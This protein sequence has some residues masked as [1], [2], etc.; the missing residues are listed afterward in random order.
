MDSKGKF[1]LK[2]FHNDNM[3]KR[4]LTADDVKEMGK[5]KILQT[6]DSIMMIGHGNFLCKSSEDEWYQLV[7]EFHVF[8]MAFSL[9][10]SCLH[11]IIKVVV[12][13]RGVLDQYI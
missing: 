3:C 9:T 2:K 1:E 5:I 11:Q 12:R 13:V 10:L 7:W 4:V 8:N 6:T